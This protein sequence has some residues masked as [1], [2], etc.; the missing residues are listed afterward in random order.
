M[1][2]S[3]AHARQSD[4]PADRRL[5][6]RLLLCSALGWAALSAA[7]QWGTDLTGAALAPSDPWVPAVFLALI[8]G[9][10]F[11]YAG[12]EELQGAPP[13][14]VL[15]LGFAALAGLA[16]L[17][18]PFGSKDVFFYAFYGKM[19]AALGANPHV[20]APSAFA[21]D[22]W[23]RFTNVWTA[24]QPSPYGPLFT[25]Q[26]WCIYTVTGGSLSA[27]LALQKALNA[28]LVAGGA[29]A[30]VALRSA[31]AASAT[32]AGARAAC[33]WLW[34][35]LVLFEGI[36]NGHNDVAVATA[37]LAATFLW[38]DARAPLAAAVLTAA[39]WYKW[40]PAAVVPAWMFWSV[41]RWGWR[42]SLS[43]ALPAVALATALCLAPFADAL[44]PMLARAASFHGVR[45]IFPD[46][47]PPPLWLL[48]RAMDGLDLFATSVGPALFH[49]LRAAAF[50]GGLCWIAW[51]RRHAPYAPRRF[52]SDTLWSLAVFFAFVPTMLWPWHLMPLCAVALALEDR[53]YERAVIGVT[54]AGLLS[55]F[56]TFTYAVAA[57]ALSAAALWIIRRR[58]AQR[59]RAQSI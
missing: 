49:A 27:A 2:T 12:V 37:L 44:A 26:M 55:Y 48:F 23:Y 14:R 13:D 19:A 25:L 6:V 54:A 56:L 46:E 10:V 7:S 28:A 32:A 59:E 39:F 41:R 36:A 43:S 51:R 50:A 52:V 1:R 18:Y 47:L 3:R 5:H 22:A 29:W 40:Y 58:R 15:W 57:C 11:S 4:G 38:I 34:S 45:Q 20:A 24:D 8:A 31:T 16:M 53:R 21:S 17:T 30:L 35:P 42:S 33:L 9:L